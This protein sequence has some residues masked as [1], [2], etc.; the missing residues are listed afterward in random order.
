MEAATSLSRI[1]RDCAIRDTEVGVVIDATA[2]YCCN[3]P[4][5]CGIGDGDGATLAVVDAAAE[6]SRIVGDGRIGDGD[7]ATVVVVDATAVVI[8]FA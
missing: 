4:R 2:V 5:E 6:V 7:G 8:I 3:I 1:A